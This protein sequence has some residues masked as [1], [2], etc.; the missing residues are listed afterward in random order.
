[1]CMGGI[2][3]YLQRILPGETVVATIDRLCFAKDGFLRTE[4]DTV[5]HSL[6][7]N[8]DNHVLIVKVLS[9][10]RK[11]LTR[12][13]IIA[14]A[15]LSSGGTVSK[16]LDELE[17]SGFIESY[18]QYA[19]SK[20][21]LYRLSDEYSMFFLKFIKDQRPSSG[22]VWRNMYNQSSYR[23]WSG[24]SFESVC[25]KHLDQIK[26]GL[27]IQGIQTT[28]GSWAGRKEK[29]GAQIDLL[30]D[31]GD[32]AINICEIKFCNSEFTVT[33]SYASNIFNKVNAF[34]EESKTKKN[35]F[36]TMLT[37]FGTRKNKHFL[38]HVQDEL[39]MKDLFT[40]V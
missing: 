12:T 17:Q 31:R 1:M 10:V 27:G 38:Q 28:S 3:H 36:V 19:G 21:A 30:I 23:I 6:F 33:K 24:F 14:K 4:F 39:T 7:K 2:P 34:K 11:G 9:T 18:Q 26:K 13:A 29:Q 16:T 32:N 15:K 40:W 35:V 8:A 25:L 37:T 22:G 20:D 5:F